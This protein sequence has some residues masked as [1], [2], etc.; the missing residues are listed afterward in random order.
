MDKENKTTYDLFKELFNSNGIEYSEQLAAIESCDDNQP[1]PVR[2]LII[3]KHTEKDVGY[4]GF[5]TEFS[6]SENG[7]S[8]L[9]AGP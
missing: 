7:K 3:E 4:T 8:L 5:Y 1:T 2:Q 6:F 9:H